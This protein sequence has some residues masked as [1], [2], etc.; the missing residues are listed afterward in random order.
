MK[1]GAVIA[2]A[3]VSSRMHEFKPLMCLNEHT[4]ITS[5]ILTLRAA[6]VQDVG[7]VTGYRAEP[8]ERHVAP[9]GVTI[10]RNERYAETKMFDSVLLGL[11]ALGGDVDAV[12]I[13][14]GDVPLVSPATIR[15]MQESDGDIV[16]PSCRGQIGHPVLLRR[17]CIA[18]VRSYGGRGG[19]HGAVKA[20][21]RGVTD[22]EVDD[23]GILLD[24]DTPQDYRFL[25]KEEMRLRNV[26]RLYPDVH[27]NVAMGATVITPEAALFLEM[28]GHTGSIQGACACVHI[29]YTKGW[30]LLNTIEGA[31]GYPLVVRTQGGQT[32]GGSE[33]TEKGRQFL[34]SYQGLQNELR[35]TAGRLFASFF[36]ESA[37]GARAGV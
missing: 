6:G 23:G 25:R 26:G 12:F 24:A 27:I 21:Q 19:L 18:F 11:D 31:L 28:I 22:V 4:M 17:D 14:P 7:V 20:M 5:V 35:E 36:P 2:A 32:G 1:Y 3:G 16:R 34:R 13:A 29:S 8:L 30:K 37:A 33:L 9:L 10:R 15:A